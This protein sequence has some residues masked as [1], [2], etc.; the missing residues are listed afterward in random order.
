MNN[1]ANQ[2][3]KHLQEIVEEW[4]APEDF[5]EIARPFTLDSL[6]LKQM[7]YKAYIAGSKE[8]EL[9]KANSPV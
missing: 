1:V 9:Y 2:F 7:L 3:Q 8:K 6:V 4:Q 5:W